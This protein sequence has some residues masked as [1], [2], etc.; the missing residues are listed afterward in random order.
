MW[1]VLGQNYELIYFCGYR[2]IIEKPGR[3]LAETNTIL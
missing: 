1:I 2:N 3:I